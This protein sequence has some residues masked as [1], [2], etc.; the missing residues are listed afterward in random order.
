MFYFCCQKWQRGPHII[1]LGLFV[2][3]EVVA[4]ITFRSLIQSEFLNI[5]ILINKITPVSLGSCTRVTFCVGS[6]LLFL[7]LDLFLINCYLLPHYHF[8]FRT[9]LFSTFTSAFYHSSCCL[10]LHGLTWNKASCLLMGHLQCVK[11]TNY[12]MEFDRLISAKPLSLFF[13]STVSCVKLLE[14]SMSCYLPRVLGSFFLFFA[15][16][17]LFQLE[18]KVWMHHVTRLNLQ[19]ACF[20]NIIN[21]CCA[22][23][24]VISIWS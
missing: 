1:E 16:V 17:F 8:T 18:S 23:S 22:A 20:L 4:M 13:S 6:C 14:D 5:L 7:F 15:F 12:L 24:P 10:F 9:L 21:P 2:F 11:T 19:S 3:L